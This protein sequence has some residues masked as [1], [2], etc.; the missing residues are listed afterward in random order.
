MEMEPDSTVPN[1]TGAVLLTESI[2]SKLNGEIERYG[3]SKLTSMN[4]SKEFRAGTR[5]LKW[6]KDRLTM[7]LEDLQNKWTDIQQ[8][9]LSKESRQTLISGGNNNTTNDDINDDYSQLDKASKTTEEYLD[10]RLDELEK[11]RKS[12]KEAVRAK[13]EENARL[14]KETK[15]LEAEVEAEKLELEKKRSEVLELEGGNRLGRMMKKN[16]LIHK[17]KEQHELIL[18]LQDQLD[19][20]MFRS[21]PSLG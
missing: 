5:M 4:E 16:T 2:V 14:E 9:K 10:K 17:I 18:S 3:E 20:Y 11:A 15:L 7:E 21:F 6:E 13:E 8:T 19:T 12:V 1:L